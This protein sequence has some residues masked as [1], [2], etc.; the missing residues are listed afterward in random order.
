M[1]VIIVV[2][3]K[4]RV[5]ISHT[6]SP[7][8]QRLRPEAFAFFRPDATHY[9]YHYIIIIIIVLRSM[10]YRVHVCTFCSVH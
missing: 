8:S 1:I 3:R 5:V 4:K 9:H 6:L 7:K 2:E 10:E